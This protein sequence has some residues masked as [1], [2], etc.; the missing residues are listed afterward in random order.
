M[1]LLVTFLRSVRWESCPK[2]TGTFR[3]TPVEVPF[4]NRAAD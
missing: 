2:D 1:F 3:D 4:T